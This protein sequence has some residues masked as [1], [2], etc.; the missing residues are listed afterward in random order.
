MATKRALSK[1]AHFGGGPQQGEAGGQA[2]VAAPVLDPRDGP[3]QRVTGRPVLRV[4]E[5][6]QPAGVQHGVPD[7]EGAVLHPGVPALLDHEEIEGDGGFDFGC[8]CTCPRFTG[9]GG[10]YGALR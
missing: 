6:V 4:H 9:G 3:R 7:R 10:S 8:A 1:A 5:V 2:R